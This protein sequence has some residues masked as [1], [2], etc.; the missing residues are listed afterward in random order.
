M[1]KVT[2]KFQVTVPVEVRERLGIKVGDEVE[3]EV[4]GDRALLKRKLVVEE[5]L[6]AINEYAGVLREAWPKVDR[7][8]DLMKALRGN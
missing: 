5:K 1:P 8:D 3:F 6:R 7:T 2:S 4:E